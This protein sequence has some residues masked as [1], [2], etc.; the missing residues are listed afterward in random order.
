MRGSRTRCLCMH[1]A[2]TMYAL[3]CCM[4]RAERGQ[5]PKSE[6]TILAHRGKRR[7]PLSTGGGNSG[8]KN[9]GRDTCHACLTGRGPRQTRPLRVSKT[10]RPLLS[11]PPVRRRGPLWRPHG[12]HG[13]CTSLSGVFDLL[14]N[15]GP[16]LQAPSPKPQAQEDTRSP[17]PRPPS[18][19]AQIA[20]IGPGCKTGRERESVSPYPGLLP[21]PQP[22]LALGAGMTRPGRG[23]ISQATTLQTPSATAAR[24][25][26]A[27]LAAATSEGDT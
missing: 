4:P 8:T 14:W 20:Q 22:D 25:M 12:L 24:R 9:N 7:H 13:G 3:A 23:P 16:K 11:T 26:S 17:L 2:S 6:R 27:S 1:A 15:L 21:A 18:T 10:G 5:G 19:Q